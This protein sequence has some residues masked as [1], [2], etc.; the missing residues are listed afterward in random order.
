MEF[1]ILRA[2]D[3]VNA[4]FMWKPKRPG[5]AFAPPPQAG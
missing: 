2:W 4:W 5:A 1:L 3:G